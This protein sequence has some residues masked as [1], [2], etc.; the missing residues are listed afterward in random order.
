LQV[1]K[2][3][4]TFLCIKFLLILVDPINGPVQIQVIFDSDVIIANSNHSTS[5]S[6]PSPS[7]SADGNHKMVS[8][9]IGSERIRHMA[10]PTAVG[11]MPNGGTGND[12][13]FQNVRF[14][15]SYFT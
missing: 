1:K 12:L 3:N 7:T 11:P 13:P 4:I 14:I 6:S 2:N 9:A 5:P 10:I 8:A 15:S